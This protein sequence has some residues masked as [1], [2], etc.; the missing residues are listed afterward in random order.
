MSI[1]LTPSTFIQLL[2]TILGL[3]VASILWNYSRSPRLAFNK[4]LGASI[5]SLS[6]GLGIGFIVAS[7]MALQY[8]HF[9]R[10]G[11]I[12]ALA[13][14]PFSYLYF[15]MAATRLAPSRWDWLHG[16]P[17][18]FY[19]VDFFPFFFLPAPDK[20]A[21]LKSDIQNLNGALT[22]DEGWITP[23]YVHLF[24]REIQLIVY[25]LLQAR[26]LRSI[27]RLNIP[28]LVHENRAW[29]RWTTMY[30]G[31]QSLTFLPLLAVI[32]SGQWQYT[33]LA[34]NG[35]IASALVAMTLILFFRPSILYGIR[36]LIIYEEQIHLSPPV[37][38]APIKNGVAAGIYLDYE[39]VSAL[40]S[41][42]ET[43]MQKQSPFLKHGYSSVDL[44]K[45]LAIQPYQLSAFLNHSIGANFND[46]I[47]EHRIRFC[48]ERIN[49]GAWKEF[50]L[51]AIGFECGFSNRNTFTSSFKKFVGQAPSVYLSRWEEQDLPKN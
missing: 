27:F 15:R 37:G 20:L 48:L 43:L 47:N 18:L 35:L 7:G 30:L 31:L 10:T 38:D 4:W 36:G 17:M 9:Y 51:E 45:D 13:F 19:I 21:M 2:A 11:N 6:C 40:Q 25:W 42:I 50:T 23:P 5:F 8:P 49:S 33:Y 44:A 16:L 41:K 24:I 34:N 39:T 12:F 32:I 1:Q 28:I 26:L 22:Y 3:L 46:Y 29:L 14:M